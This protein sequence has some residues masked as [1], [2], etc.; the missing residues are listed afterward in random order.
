MC[1]VGR[2]LAQQVRDGESRK[3]T[4]LQ[5]QQNTECIPKCI[6]SVVYTVVI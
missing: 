6:P 2:Q 1:C 3:I 4:Q 5:K